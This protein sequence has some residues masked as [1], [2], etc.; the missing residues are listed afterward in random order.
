MIK[1]CESY[2]RKYVVLFMEHGIELRLVNTNLL[3]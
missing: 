2:S 1:K 3:V